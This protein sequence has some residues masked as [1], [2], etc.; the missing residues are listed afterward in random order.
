MTSQRHVGPAE[1]MLRVLNRLSRYPSRV[2]S[3]EDLRKDI[4]GYE[5]GPAGDRNWQFDSQALR[6]RGL[7]KTGI[8]MRHTP[9]R[10]GVKYALPAKPDDLHLS[11]QEHAALVAARR[12]RGTS[13]IPN[14]MGRDTTR[15]GQLEILAVAL[16]RLEECGEWMTVGDLA[17]E[18]GQRPARLLK[19]L[20][21]AWCLEVDGLS[22]F[23]NRLDVDDGGGDLSAANTLI[24]VLRRRDLERPLRGRGLA[25]VGAGAYTLDEIA[26]RLDLI[27]EVMAGNLPGPVDVLESAKHKL[28]RWQ[29][30][31]RAA[32]NES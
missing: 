16:R 15:G 19:T 27:E 8:T 21:L 2:W 20:Q 31:L 32:L 3:V 29:G 25:L 9:R 13:E 14:P 10:T 24:C 4:P 18:M 23:E 26:E 1:R 17:R 12:A 28:L 6:D 30:T 7:I 11:E 22:V 5:D